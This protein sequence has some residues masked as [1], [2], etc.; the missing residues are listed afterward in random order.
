F[1]PR[2]GSVSGGGGELRNQSIAE[3]G[4]ATMKT[5]DTRQLKQ[6]IESGEEFVLINTLD[7]EHFDDTRIPRSINIP[8]SRDDF[9]EQVEKE[10]SGK[11]ATIVVYCA[12]ESCNSSTKGAQ[13]LIDAG[14]RDVIDYEGGAETWKQAG[15]EL[16]PA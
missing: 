6:K 10:A 13:K 4:E 2:R 14:F 15:H 12:S 9:V 7:E 16:V 3:R 11:D 1:G 8:Q 5:I